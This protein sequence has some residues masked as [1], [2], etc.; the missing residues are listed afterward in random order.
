MARKKSKR[1]LLPRP[2]N[3]GTMTNGGFWGMIRAALRQ[4]SRWWKPV[5][6]VKRKARRPYKGPNK[7]QRFEYQC[8]IC[9]NYFPE[10]KINVDHKIPAGSLLSSDD[11][12]GFVERLFVEEPGL[13]VLCSGCHDKKTKQELDNKKQKV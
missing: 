13:Q 11:L 8:A 10:K 2:Y 6:N 7:R 12:K 9:L 5:A 4:K 1:K 3:A